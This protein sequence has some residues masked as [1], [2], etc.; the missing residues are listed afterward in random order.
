VDLASSQTSN[1]KGSTTNKGSGQVSLGLGLGG[2][3]VGS[4]GLKTARCKSQGSTKCFSEAN[5]SQVEATTRRSGG[6]DS[7]KWTTSGKN[8]EQRHVERDDLNMPPNLGLS[9]RRR[10]RLELMNHVRARGRR[11]RAERKHRPRAGKAK[12]RR[13]MARRCYVS[14]RIAGEPTNQRHCTGRDTA[15]WPIE[16]KINKI[17]VFP[18]SRSESRGQLLKETGERGRKNGHRVRSLALAKCVGAPNTPAS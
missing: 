16:N 18:M 17:I 2:W 13:I 11:G 15:R 14:R 12:S 6:E 3:G 4:R 7:N 8:V 10:S 1:R 5:E 9:S